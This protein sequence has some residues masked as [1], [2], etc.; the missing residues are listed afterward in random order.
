MDDLKTILSNSPAPTST[1]P[2]TQAA[3]N[4]HYKDR[5]CVI[6][7]SG[8]SKKYFGKEYIHD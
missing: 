2:T 7:F 1:P 6:I 3:E 5:L 8:D 4:I